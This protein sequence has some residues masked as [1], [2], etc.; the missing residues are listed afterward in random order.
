MRITHDV[1]IADNEIEL[2]AVRAQGAG[3]QNVN[4]VSSAIHLRFNIATSSLPQEYKDRLMRMADRRISDEGIIV[5]KAQRYRS[6]EQNRTDALERLRALILL[7]SYAPKKRLPTKPG[8][9]AVKRRI[10]NKIKRGEIKSL[11][12][13][14]F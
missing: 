5:L 10:D 9:N 11:R 6:Q 4:K 1:E 13:K 8:K 3:G 7:A 12:S 14:V 2:H